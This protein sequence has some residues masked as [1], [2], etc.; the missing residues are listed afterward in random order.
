MTRRW[1]F[2]K[3][4]ASMN[5]ASRSPL[6]RQGE[7]TKSDNN[8]PATLRCV[9]LGRSG[10]QSDRT[11]HIWDT[12]LFLCWSHGDLISPNCTHSH[13]ESIYVRSPN[14]FPRSALVCGN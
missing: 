9:A 1:A 4:L 6:A 8:V 5:R 12:S 3:K 7:A 13:T 2:L 14:V 10:G 11:T